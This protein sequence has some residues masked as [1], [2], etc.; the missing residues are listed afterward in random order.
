MLIKH[1]IKVYSKLFV[2]SIKTFG[3][4]S[5][6]FLKTLGV[7]FYLLFTHF[8]LFL[9][10]IFFPGYKDVEIKNPIFIIG[11]PRS[12]TTFFHRLM[13][14]TDEFLSFKSWHL[15]FPSLT[16]RKLFKPM[17]MNKIAN[18]TH[19]MFPPETGHHTRLD[20]VEEEEQLYLHV[21]DTQFVS[22]IFSLAFYEGDFDEL[23]YNDE[24]AHRK[25]SIKHLKNC[26][27]R[28]IYY[29]G[30]EQVMARCNF[31]AMRIKTLAE[32]FPDAKFVY[33][34]RNPIDSI[35]SHLSLNTNVFDYKWKLDKIGEEAM[36]RYYDRRYRYNAEFYKYFESVKD[37]TDILKGRLIEV[38][39]NDF[40]ENFTP[41]IKRVEEFMELDFSDEM[42]KVI[43]E[44]AEAQKSYKRKH[45]N[46]DLT[47]FGLTEERIREELDFMFSKIETD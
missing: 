30:K 29:T 13:L 3:I 32:E 41:T 27:K 26:I 36:N 33:I 7:P 44:Q 24:Q 5:A 34:Y 25:S 38:F 19:V 31:S 43:E 10:N 21:C 47:K 22:I 39:Y 20:T 28:H 4:F 40:L 15:Q 17:V 6:D 2:S 8:C 12:G 1:M 42:K 23:L 11:H 45:K 16:A 37:E 46:F 35:N 9:D 14:R 18:G